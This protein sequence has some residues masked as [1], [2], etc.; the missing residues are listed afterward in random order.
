M[1]GNYI[2]RSIDEKGI[3]IE[4]TDWKYQTLEAYYVVDALGM[5]SDKAMA[6]SFVELIPDVYVAGDADAPKNIK[7][8]NYT[9][10]NYCCNI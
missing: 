10:Y 1:I 4:N 5:K 6:D 7:H 9:A 2:I 8:A 3:L